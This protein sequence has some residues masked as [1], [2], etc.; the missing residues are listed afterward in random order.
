MCA[1]HIHNGLIMTKGLLYVST[2]PK[3]EAEGILVFLVLTDQRCVAINGVHHDAG[4]QGQ[5]RTLVLTQERFW[6]PIMVQGCQQCNVFEGALPK[7]PLCPIRAH[8]PLELIHIDFTSMELTMEL[9]KPPSIKNV[10]VITDHFMCYALAFVMRDQTAK[11]MAKILYE[12]FITV[13][14]SPAKLLSD[15]DTNFT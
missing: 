8:M 4:H 11:T 14:G 7:V 6:W 13:F 12:R 5:Q 3:R 2:T 15:C 1:L 10:I 9:N